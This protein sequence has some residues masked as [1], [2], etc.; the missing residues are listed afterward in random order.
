[1]YIYIYSMLYFYSV[2]LHMQRDDPVIAVPCSSHMLL[3]KAAAV[4]EPACVYGFTSP[5]VGRL[6]LRTTDIDANNETLV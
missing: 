5:D 2:I 4:H 6:I 3:E 1:M